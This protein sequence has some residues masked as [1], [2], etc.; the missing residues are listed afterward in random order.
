MMNIATGT[1]LVLANNTGNFASISQI[2]LG[3]GG[4]INGNLVIS[5]PYQ[6][7]EFMPF[8]SAS[9]PPAGASYYFSGSG[10]INV[11][12]PG[13][14]LATHKNSL[15][16]PTSPGWNAYV[17]VPIVLNSSNLPFTAFDVTKPIFTTATAYS[18]YSGRNFGTAIAATKWSVLTI[19][20]PISGNADALFTCN[21]FQTGYGGSAITSVSAQCT[22]TGTTMLEGN[23]ALDST[24]GGLLTIPPGTGSLILG[25]SNALPVATNVEFDALTGNPTQYPVLDLNGNNTR[26]GSLTVPPN[27]TNQ[28]TAIFIGSNAGAATLTVSGA[29]TPN[30]GYGGSLVDCPL[31]VFTP[32]ST[33]SGTLAL[34]KDGPNTLNLSGSNTYSGGTSI[35]GGYLQLSNPNSNASATGVGPVTVYGG[36]LAGSLVGGSASGAVTVQSGG[37]IMP[38]GINASGAPLTLGSTL[39]MQAG[40]NLSF[41]FGAHTSTG[42]AQVEAAGALTLPT[43]A[44]SVTVDLTP[45][46]GLY[47]VI[48]LF[49]YSSL[50]NGTASIASLD[51][52]NS[53][54]L[55]AGYTFVLD[56]TLG[57]LGSNN[58]T[59][60]DLYNPN[61]VNPKPLTW[62][63]T[64][65]A[66]RGTP[67]PRILTGKR[68]AAPPVLLSRATS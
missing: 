34:V 54:S 36:A 2:A 18:A 33:A 51:L 66:A 65:R 35:Y 29:T 64:A 45:Q 68:R 38:G 30:Y 53:A 15:G 50:T 27:V 43:L 6:E 8:P 14:S 13:S 11:A 48:P 1:T 3:A 61:I 16:S 39:T 42:S 31:K 59:Q 19:Q 37:E 23:G 67:T 4:T 57:T 12:A 46:A 9:P 10:T 56:S 28:S 40:S 47:S 25:V 5:Q 63:A 58:A 49:S 7:I 26:I 55:P 52:G 60:I 32:S 22:Y 41:V 62:S 20:Q 17:N 44:N 24:H 21:T